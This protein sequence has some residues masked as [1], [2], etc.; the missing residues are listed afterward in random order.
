MS[1]IGE[2]SLGKNEGKE[3]GTNDT[4]RPRIVT[5]ATVGTPATVS[6]PEVAGVGLVVHPDVLMQTIVAATASS[7][8][9]LMG[10]MG[11][12]KTR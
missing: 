9:R 10:R 2:L 8:R 7:W 12:K 4:S 3:A 11:T 5:P 1:W 6:A